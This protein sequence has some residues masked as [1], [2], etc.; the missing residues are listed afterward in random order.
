MLAVR[1]LDSCRHSHAALPALWALLQQNYAAMTAS[2]NEAKWLLQAQ[3]GTFVSALDAATRATTFTTLSTYW[4]EPMRKSVMTPTV[5]VSG[6]VGHLDIRNAAVVLLLQGLS[7]P[8][9][10]V[11]CRSALMPLPQE[12]IL[13]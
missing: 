3:E 9:C 5:P 13:T 11:S 1:A 7:Q 10:A 12:F 8:P 6:K 4:R 2:Q